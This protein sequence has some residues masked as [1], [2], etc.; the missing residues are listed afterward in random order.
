MRKKDGVEVDG[1]PRYAL[2][3]RNELATYS[4]SVNKTEEEDEERKNCCLLYR[5]QNQN[6]M[7]RA[8]RP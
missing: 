5:L 6:Q 7:M 1:F 8:I 3:F 2:S 4:E